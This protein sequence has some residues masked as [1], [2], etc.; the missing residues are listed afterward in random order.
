MVEFAIHGHA[1]HASPVLSEN[2]LSLA[3]KRFVFWPTI[4]L[5]RAFRIA[6]VPRSGR[7]RRADGIG[8]REAIHQ[9]RFQS[10]LDLPVGRSDFAG[11][12]G[13]LVVCRGIEFF[14]HGTPP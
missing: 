4:M 14:S 12:S 11:V 8:G 7:L 5:R 3:P 2:G 13:I 1:R 9:A 6:I 10:R